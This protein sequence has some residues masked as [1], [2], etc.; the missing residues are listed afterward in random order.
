MA[1]LNNS[2]NWIWINACERGCY[3]MNDRSLLGEKELR[4]LL[5]GVGPTTF[6]LGPQILYYWPFN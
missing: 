4:V 2:S 5:V 6:R 3:T 1:L